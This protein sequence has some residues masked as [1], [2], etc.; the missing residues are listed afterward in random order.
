[1][2]IIQRRGFTVEPLGQLSLLASEGFEAAAWTQSNVF[3]SS[4]VTIEATGETKMLQVHPV[5]GDQATANLV[6]MEYG[7]K[8]AGNI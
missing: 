6:A 2:S 4:R 8:R 7:N 1:M 3:F 5:F